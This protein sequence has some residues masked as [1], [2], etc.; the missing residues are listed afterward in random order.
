MTFSGF[1]RSAL[2]ELGRL[3]SLDA[4]GY[5]SRREQLNNGLLVPARA[6]LDE[7]VAQL[8]APLTTSARASVSPLHTDLRFAAAGAPRY[9]DHLLLTTWHGPDKKF[10]PTLWIRVNSTSVGFASGIAFTPLV[11]E[12]WRAA[13]AGA[14][15]ARLATLIDESRKR[16]ARHEFE[17]A[18]DSV[19][20][21]PQPWTDEHPRAELLR[22]TGFQV[23]FRI[24]LPREV[25]R[26]EF[27]PWCAERLS[28]LLPTHRWLVKHLF[29][30]DNAG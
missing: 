19:H 15:G 22:K 8:D 4:V 13:V 9:K 11:R 27:A 26:P 18:G 29:K 1:I 5:A 21:V 12:R 7:V 20:R 3:P 25:E 17:V 6:L 14:A 2:D 10:G 16:H 28:E 30:E 24:P 23:R